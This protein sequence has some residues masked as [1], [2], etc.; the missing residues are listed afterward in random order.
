MVEA[1]P[2]SHIS[3]TLWLSSTALVPL[4]EKKKEMK[5]EKKIRKCKSRTMATNE[6]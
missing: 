1:R 4:K 5:K 2:T 3:H 6:Q